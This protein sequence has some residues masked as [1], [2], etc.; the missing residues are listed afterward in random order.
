METR[1]PLRNRWMD[2][3]RV[4]ATCAV[5]ML[6][7]VTCC[8]DRTDMR[9]FVSQQ[10]IFLIC[11]DLLSWG[12]PVFLILSGYI[13]LNP[14]KQ[15]SLKIMITKYCKRIV[16]ALF[17]FGV[18]Y[19]CLEQIAI[20]R[21]F[22]LKMIPSSFLMVIQG[23][24]WS[25]LWYLYLIVGLYIV[26]PLLKKTLSMIP[27][28]SVVVVMI[29]ILMGSSVGIYI[30]MVLGTTRLPTIPSDMIYLFYYLYGYLLVTKSQ[31]N[32]EKSTSVKWEGILLLLLFIGI[33]YSRLSD[34]YTIEMP[35]NY[36][37]TIIM[38]LLI[39]RFVQAK[40]N[41]WQQMNHQLRRLSAI[42]FTVYLIHPVFLNIFYKFFHF[43]PLSFHCFLSLPFFWSLTLCLSIL[44]ALILEKTPFLKKFV[45]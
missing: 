36:P 22:H 19:A 29:A 6:H 11:K 7:T 37:T 20:A 3:L 17:V 38:S 8:L 40:E 23:K 26:T 39:V 45:L 33:I 21:T 15:V 18:P 16:L 44:G 13:F 34:G 28:W 2:L 27:K 25:H 5:V 24:S 41:C 1:K 14:S 4:G 42:S 10:K 43:T 12:V 9:N 30:N 31:E 35:Y 32:E